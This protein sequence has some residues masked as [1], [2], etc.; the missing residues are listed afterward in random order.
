MH[1]HAYTFSLRPDTVA[2]T[3]PN[4]ISRAISKKRV[5]IITDIAKT[6]RAEFMQH[7]IGKTVSVLIEENNIGRTPDDIDVK[8]NG[9]MIP[10]KTICNI[11]LIGMQ[12]GVFVGTKE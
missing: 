1:E 6:N 7:Q 4:Q 11:K 10:N 2:A 9:P 8:V 12:D 3:L 5:K